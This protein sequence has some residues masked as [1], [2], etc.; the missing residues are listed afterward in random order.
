MSD[1]FEQALEFEWDQG[2]LDKNWVKHRVSAQESETA[3]LDPKAFLTTDV[4]HSTAEYRYQLL[5]QAKPG[6]Y[7]TIHFTLRGNKIRIISARPMSKK[8]RTQYEKI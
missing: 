2:N 1:I 5:A 4:S 7:L 8:E 3:F 6:R